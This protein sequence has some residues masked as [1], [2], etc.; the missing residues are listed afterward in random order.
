L[1]EEFQNTQIQM[2]STSGIYF[3]R[4]IS[5]ENNFTLRIVRE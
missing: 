2:P 4:I 5:E 1:F 3:L